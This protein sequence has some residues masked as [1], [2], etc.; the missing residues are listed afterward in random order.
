MGRGIRGKSPGSHP[1]AK[2]GVG[3]GGHLLVAI[4][5]VCAI[6]PFPGTI[7]LSETY[8]GMKGVCVLYN[9]F[10]ENRWEGSF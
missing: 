5:V 7:D 1:Q 2:L 3:R 10:L 9:E 8:P 4:T 6:H